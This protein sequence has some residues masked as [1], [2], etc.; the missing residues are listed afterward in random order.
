MRRPIRVIARVVYHTAGNQCTKAL[1]QLKE[2]VA[3]LPTCKGPGSLELGT[4]LR[5]RGTSMKVALVSSSSELPV[6]ERV[7]EY[8]LNLSSYTSVSHY[9]T[10]GPIDYYCGVVLLAGTSAGSG[11]HFLAS[12]IWGSATCSY[13]SAESD[14]QA[15]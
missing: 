15:F 5:Q 3:D 2:P 10:M 14:D 11:E 7:D 1:W 12:S 13:R 8:S 6:K 9:P 4:E